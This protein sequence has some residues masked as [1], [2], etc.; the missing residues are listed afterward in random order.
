MLMQT[1]LS[2]YTSL[3]STLKIGSLPLIQKATPRF[4]PPTTH[5]TD[6]LALLCSTFQMLTLE[7]LNI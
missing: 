4:C 1:S 7:F 6:P 2:N 5:V 3:H